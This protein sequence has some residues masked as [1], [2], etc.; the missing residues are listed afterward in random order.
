MLEWH[1]K[2]I[3]D[4]YCEKAEEMKKYIMEMTKD[5]EEKEKR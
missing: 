4:R 5:I 3:I 1:K 2:E